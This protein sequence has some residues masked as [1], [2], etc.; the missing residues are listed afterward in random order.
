MSGHRDDG[1]SA[2]NKAH[3]PNRKVD[4]GMAQYNRYLGE[5]EEPSENTYEVQT[6]KKGG[7]YTTHLTTN[8]EQQAL[9]HYDARN[10]GNGYTKRLMANGKQVKRSSYG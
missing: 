6:R 5:G 7:K 8:K 1:T 4:Q 9:A 3:H 10:V 2:E